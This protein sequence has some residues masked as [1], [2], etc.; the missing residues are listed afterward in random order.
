MERPAGHG[1][2]LQAD[3][4]GYRRRMTQRPDLFE[5][6]GEPVPEIRAD[7]TVHSPTDTETY[8]DDDIAML[9]TSLDEA[10]IIS[11]ADTETY[12][13]DAGL[14]NLAD[15]GSSSTLITRNDSET[16]DD[17]QGAWFGLGLQ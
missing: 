6:L 15:L 3:L 10:T 7:G 4:D 9:P 16:Y 8:D 17:D 5:Y 11:K 14:G 13:D 2:W 12:D 1:A